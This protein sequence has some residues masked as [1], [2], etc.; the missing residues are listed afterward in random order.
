MPLLTIN[1]EDEDGFVLFESRAIS[2]YIADKYGNGKLVPKDLKG[3]A[4]FEQA[5]SIEQSDFDP[6]AGVIVKEKVFKP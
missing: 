6:F 5:V 3:R 2:R 4:L 1:Q